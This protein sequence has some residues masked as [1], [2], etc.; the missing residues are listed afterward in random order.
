VK[1]V[2]TQGWARRAH[3][4]L[5]LALGVA[6]GTLLTSPAYGA[7]TAIVLEVR[8]AIGP[9]TSDY[10]MRGLA[11][12]AQS[13]AGLVILRMDTPG[14]LDTSMREIIRAILS[15]T[16]P[17][18]TYVAPS[19]ARA[20]SAGT[21][22][23]Y[24]SH[25]AA[26]APG[27]NIG[28]AT[29]VSLGLGGESPPASPTPRSGPPLSTPPSP[30]TMGTKVTND[31][32]AYIRSLAE[33]RERNAD[34]A[35]RA[36]R[37]AASLTAT[38]AQ[39]QHVIDF[40]ATDIGELLQKADDRTVILAGRMTVLH[41]KD[42]AIETLAPDWR[43]RVLSIVAD[44]NVALIFMTLG[45][46]GLIF[47]FLNP[48]LYLPGVAGGISLLVGLYA[49]AIL[50]VTFSGLTLIFLGVALM[51]AEVFAPSGV[52]ATGGLVAFVVGAA[53]LIEPGAG[54]VAID[55]RI[56]APLAGA[57]LALSLLILRLAL[58]S[59]NRRVVTGAAAMIGAKGEVEDWAVA[60]GRILVLGERWNAVSA[61]PLAPGQTVRVS[62]VNG[63][64]LTVE[65]LDPR[66]S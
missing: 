9:A 14:G 31:A 49:L 65:P 6:C 3:A 20:A 25:I 17:V 2:L 33:L 40:L 44:P 29:P 27:T 42:L 35:E 4:C 47:E 12:A 54:G 18:A 26:M 11:R 48:G 8:G 36:V 34:W 7:R 59:R 51:I 19:G 63:L 32:V 23:A 39:K 1:A 45:V 66:K 10:V 41:T 13:G 50:P 22:I 43:T 38:D 37:Q 57:S 46:Y 56:V 53:I 58:K 60:K 55:W 30:P 61:R 21:Y 24:A 28:A 62:S 64:T 52:L 5:R 15:S 16:V